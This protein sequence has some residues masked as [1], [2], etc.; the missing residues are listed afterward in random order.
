MVLK[1][2][3]KREFVKKEENFKVSRGIFDERTLMNLYRLLNSGTIAT[4]ESSIK[5]GKESVILAGL[6]KKGEWIAIKVYRTTACDYRNMWKYLVGDPRF[7][8]LKKNR[9][10]VVSLWCKKEFK[11]LRMARDADID[12]PEPIAFRENVLIME[13]IGKN[14]LPAPRL[15]DIELDKPKRTYA[16]ILKNLEKL[17]NIGLIHGDLSAFNILFYRKPHLIDFSQS[18]VLKHPL[19]LELLRRD[20]RNINNYF[21]K[22]NVSVENDE[23]IY[24]KLLR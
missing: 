20:I 2:K 9:R 11:N 4:V 15:V 12:C 7:K 21:S 22:L 10:I 18:V 16:M 14:G 17:V 19:A 6:D 24:K 23:K 8:G 13:F 5:E 1:R 3:R